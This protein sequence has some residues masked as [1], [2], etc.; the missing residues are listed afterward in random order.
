MEAEIADQSVPREIKALFRNQRVVLRETSRAV[1]PFG[2]VAVFAVFLQ[3]GV[4]AL[5]Q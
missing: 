5:V 3:S 1:T 4:A 2:G